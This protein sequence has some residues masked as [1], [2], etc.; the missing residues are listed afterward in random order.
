MKNR[1]ARSP[2]GLRLCVVALGLVLGVSAG[3]ACASVWC[4]PERPHSGVVLTDREISEA[5]EWLRSADVDEQY[6]GLER[7]V[8]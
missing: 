6:K 5:T 7:L 2:A 8:P 1:V 3:P 4:I